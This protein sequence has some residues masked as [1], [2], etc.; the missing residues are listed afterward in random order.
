MATPW[1]RAA[2]GYLDEWVPRFVPY[3]LDLVHELALA[4]GQRVLVTSAGPGSE[5]L[6]AA[7]AIGETGYIRA[8]DKSAEMVRLCDAQ[9]KKGGFGA[10]VDCATAD[11]TDASN[12]RSPGAKWDAVLCAFG[13]WQLDDRIGAIR[14]WRDALAPNGKVGILTWGPPD[15]DDPFERLAQ[16]LHE[17]EPAHAVPPSR[18]VSERGA[19]ESM[20][21][22]AG[23]AM[24]RHTVVRHTLSFKSA[25]SFV[26]AL[27]EACTWRR[28]WEEIGDARV[29]RLAA[30]FYEL[31]SDPDT[32]LSFEAPATLAIA[33]LPGAEVE[34]E[35]RPSIR[36]PALTPKH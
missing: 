19:M 11:A 23:L 33:A 20:F 10:F 29:E 17:L 27:R 25:E 22:E 34:L 16:C 18:I 31:T 21:A 15:A 9:V 6:A 28:I 26:K 5:V 35:H 4:P 24:V 7:R 36:V 12:P 1:D 8:T 32:P 30:R 13:L 14:A 2:V 3:H